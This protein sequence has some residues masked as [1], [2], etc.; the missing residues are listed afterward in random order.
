MASLCAHL[1]LSMGASSNCLFVS[2]DIE[3]IEFKAR[4][5]DGSV[6]LQEQNICSAIRNK[7]TA[8]TSSPS[9][10]A[11]LH[12]VLGTK[13]GLVYPSI[14]VVRQMQEEFGE[15]LVVVVDACQLRCKLH[16]VREYVQLGAFVLITGT[17]SLC[18]FKVES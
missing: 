1:H 6:Q 16:V 4:S 8:E 10:V 2:G 17:M 9:S 5:E 11:I 18:L 7:L 3:V 13:T 12:A 14:D 15:R